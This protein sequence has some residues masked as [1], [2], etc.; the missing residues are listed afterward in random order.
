MNNELILN[1]ENIVQLCYNTCADIQPIRSHRKGVN[2]MEKQF[3][4]VIGRQFGSGG[5]AVG[6]RLASQLGIPLY[7]KEILAQIAE[8]QGITAERLQK[9]DEDLKGNHMLNVG[10]QAGKFHPFHPGL[11]FETDTSAMITR[12]QAFRWQAQKIRELA[13]KGSCVIIGRCADVILKDHPGLVSVFIT[14]P[15]AVREARIARL[16]PDH[17][18][19]NG[20]THLEFIQKTDKA[21]AS[22]YSYHT[23]REWANIGNYHLCLDSSRLGIEGAADLIADY[24]KR[25]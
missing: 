11:L 9:M 1:V 18:R 4:I 10:L 7:D 12:D 2:S 13:E 14:A 16:H 17:P 20:E 8:E 24:V 22:Y 23:D 3:V 25:T 5:H 19:L 15:L 21:R 6:A